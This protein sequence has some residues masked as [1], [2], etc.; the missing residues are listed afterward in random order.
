MYLST[1]YCDYCMY[2]L[3]CKT[4]FLKA[5]YKSMLYCIV[6]WYRIA[7]TINYVTLALCNHLS[8]ESEI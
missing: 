1:L 3:S 5:R 7:N 8:H 4:F 2:A 6:V